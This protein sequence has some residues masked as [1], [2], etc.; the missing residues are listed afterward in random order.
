MK[1]SNFKSQISN[2]F[3]KLRISSKSRDILHFF[4]ENLK[5]QSG[6]TLIEIIV[7]IGTLGV[8]STIGIASFVSYSRTQ[9]INS[10]AF[11]VVTSIN[12]AKSRARTQ[13]KPSTG[14]CRVPVL[15]GYQITIV[16][17][18]TYRLEVNCEGFVDI[19]PGAT[20]TLPSN[21]NITFAAASRNKTFLFK[22]LS[23][24]VQ[25]PGG[26]QSDTIVITGFGITKTITISSNGKIA[27]N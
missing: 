6:F 21:G 10:A 8:L 11:D 16:D 27:I 20:A 25:I 17:A 22:V 19:L 24:S 2:P 7:V 18:T 1:I 5:F 4:T 14:T 26:L 12:L 3:G 13:Y 15:R 9:A 23:G